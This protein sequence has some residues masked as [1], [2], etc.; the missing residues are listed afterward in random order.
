MF[1]GPFRESMIRLAKKKGLVKI[2]V[3]NLRKFAK[4]KHKSCDDKP[5]GGGAGMVMMAEPLLKAIDFLKKHSPQAKVVLL[6]PQGKLFTQQEAWKLS[7]ESHLIFLCGHYE[8]VDERVRQYGVD[9]EVSIG[10]FITTG[11]ELP[12]M[13]LVDSLVRLVPGVLGNED[14]IQHE[15]FQGDLLEYP[16]YTRPRVFRGMTVPEVLLSGNHNKV[17]SWR[18]ERA[19]Q[20]TQERRPDLLRK[21]ND[22]N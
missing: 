17:A 3:H 11:G 5:F 2:K 1:A 21:H 22:K 12:V 19:Y 15:S 14:S 10:D 7:R 6:S 8:G 4:G 16:H 13:C 18:K 9:L 20:R